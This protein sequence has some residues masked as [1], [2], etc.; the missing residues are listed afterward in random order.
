MGLLLVCLMIAGWGIPFMNPSLSAFIVMN[1]P[2]SIVGRMVG[3]CF[4]FGTFGGALGLYLGGMTIGK[5]GTFFWAI[6]MI[7]IA[8]I[9]GFILAFFLKS[10]KA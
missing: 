9:V 10:R 5:L 1:Y 6:A 8:A 7:S 2:P 4:G 3:F